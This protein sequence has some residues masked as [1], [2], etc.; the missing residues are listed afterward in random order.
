MKTFKNKSSICQLMILA[1]LAFGFEY[2]ISFAQSIGINTTGAT[3]NAS[4]AL[5]I[6]STTKGLLI[7]RVTLCQRTTPSCPGGGLLNASGEL[8]AVAQGLVVYQT[9]GIQGFYYDT[10]TT[11]IPKWVMILSPPTGWGTTGNTGTVDGTNFLGTIDDIP[12][13]FKVFNNNAGRISS[14]LL[15]STF[16]GYQ[17][18][19][20]NTGN[21]NTG[22]GYQALFTNAATAGNTA[23]GYKALYTNI[24]NYNVAIGS[25]ALLFN[26][27]GTRNIAV[28]QGSLNSNVTGADNV[29]VGHAALNTNGFT[30]TG[31]TNNIAIG[32]W[33]LNANDIGTDNTAVGYNSLVGNENGIQNIAVGSNTLRTNVA[34]SG[35]TAIGY[36]AM[37]Y[38]NSATGATFSTKN[39]A[40]GFE[41]LKGSTTASANTG[42]NNTALGYQ[43]LLGNTSGSWN[44]ASGQNA[45]V[46]NTTGDAN[47]ANGQNTLSTN[48][49]GN[50]NTASGASALY[51]NTGSN[52]TASGVNALLTNVSGTNNTALGVAADVTVN[53]LTNATA[54]GYNAKVTTSN[55]LVLGAGANVGINVSSPTAWLHLPAGTVTAGTAPFKYTSGT[56]LTAV[57]DG[58]KE[59]DGTN[60]FLSVGGVRYTIGKTLTATASLN[61]PST[62]T[63][64]SS[65]LTITLTGAADGD[66]VVLGTPNAAVNANSCYTAWVSAANTVTVRFNNY[67]SGSINPSAGTF[68]VSIIKY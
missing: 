6:V 34:G 17:A 10:S 67:S 57:E 65:D 30:G 45:L 58:A 48:I 42:N 47:T 59:Y 38:A 27:T 40:I 7:P 43:A 35:S 3:P 63:L 36:G 37:Y 2:Q 39:V 23:V 32:S 9:D 29:A 20:V 33:S 19:N 21:M 24:G 52:N 31:A 61:F 64:T 46:A 8:A 56:N 44:T 22:I 49:S 14:V 11:V 5:D 50:W 13:T 26:T 54:I 41:A 4:S 16:F 51:N 15:S 55:S 66:I 28:G 25:N 62:S 12:L 68:R 1:F 60:E 18:G 53:N